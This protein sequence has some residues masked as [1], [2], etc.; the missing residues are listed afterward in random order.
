MA[1]FLETIV[2]G[3]STGIIIGLIGIGFVIIFKASRVL[4]LAQSEMVSAGGFIAYSLS[5]QIGITFLAALI[6]TLFIALFLGFLIERLA[7][8]PMIGQPPLSLVMMTIALAAIFNGII[9][10]IYGPNLHSYPQWLPSEPFTLGSVTIAQ[11]YV[12]G[13][14]ITIIFVCVFGLFYKYARTGIFMRA[15]ADDEQAA[16][17][18]GINVRRVYG[19]AWAIAFMVGA[20]GGMLLGTII[21]VSQYLSSMGDLAFAVIILGGLES[22][23]GSLIAG[24]I[25]GVVYNLAGTYLDQSFVGIK[26]IAPYVCMFLIL[27]IKPAGLFGTKKVERI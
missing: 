20:M 16:L 13:T 15:V 14:I 24:I 6:L 27:L 10:A 18:V 7:L 3:F 4:N 2:S 22:I 8:R 19:S 11:E 1:I 5:V 25:L 12:W 9:L 21:S 26:E 23:V 17:S